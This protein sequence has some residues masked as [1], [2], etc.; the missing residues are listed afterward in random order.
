MIRIILALF[1]VYVVLRLLQRGSSKKTSMGRDF[2]V[3][4]PTKKST[5]KDDAGEVVNFEEVKD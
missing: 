2:S 5:I 1:A 4:T 3:K